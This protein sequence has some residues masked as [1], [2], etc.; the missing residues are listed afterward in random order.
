MTDK[1]KAI[2]V[3][4]F[5]LSIFLAGCPGTNSPANNPPYAVTGPASIEVL[6]GVIR[7]FTVETDA[8]G[9]ELDPDGDYAFFNSD[10]LPPYLE[11]YDDQLGTFKS[12]NAPTTGTLEIS[13]WIE[14]EHGLSSTACTI[15]LTFTSS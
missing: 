8:P 12:D 7:Y 11:I 9:S 1:Y 4:F 15:T 3:F 14:D 6:G 10:L 5:L 2:G 13:V